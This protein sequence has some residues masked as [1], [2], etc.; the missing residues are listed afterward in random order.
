MPLPTNEKLLGKIP[1]DHCF[2]LQLPLS[3]AAL[4]FTFLLM[5]H[6][7]ESPSG[8]NDILYPSFPLKAENKD[9]STNYSEDYMKYMRVKLV[10][11]KP[12]QC[13]T[14]LQRKKER[15]C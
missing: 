13:A 5:N 10:Q 11:S 7:P 15:D 1:I 14:S 2:V 9:V 6:I 8:S 12:L 4:D 3:F